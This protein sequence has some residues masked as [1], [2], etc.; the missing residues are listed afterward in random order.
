[1]TDRAWAAFVA[2]FG[3]VGMVVGACAAWGFGGMVF[4]WGLMVFIK[5]IADDACLFLRSR[6]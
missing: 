6:K 5:T 2:M 1:M 4:A 3:M